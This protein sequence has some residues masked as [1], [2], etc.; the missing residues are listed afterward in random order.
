MIKKTL[1]MSLIVLAFNCGTIK[2]AEQPTKSPE[3]TEQ[4]QVPWGTWVL[5]QRSGGI[6]GATHTFEP[7]AKEKVL[8]IEKNKLIVWEK[9]IKKS[10]QAFVIEKGKVLESAV[11]QDILKGEESLPQSIKF[12]DGNLILRTQC[13]DCYTEVYQ[14]IQ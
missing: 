9:D 7:A 11:L 3:N 5:V 10:E 8:L 1:G 13:Y 14:R 12:K 2:T 4:Q 6:T